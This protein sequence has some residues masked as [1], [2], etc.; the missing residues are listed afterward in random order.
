MNMILST[1][2]F[3][4]NFTPLLL[5]WLNI[6]EVQTRII[7]EVKLNNEVNIYLAN[8]TYQSTTGNIVYCTCPKSDANLNNF[9]CQCYDSRA[10]RTYK[11]YTCSCV[12]STEEIDF[13]NCKCASLEDRLTVKCSVSSDKDTIKLGVLIPHTLGSSNLS[14]YFSGD[15]YSSAMF[16]AKDDINQNKFLL[17]NKTVDLVWG[18]TDCNKTKTIKLA[19]KMIE[20]YH[21]DAIVGVGCEGCL[22]TATITGAYNI[23]MISHVRLVLFIFLLKQ[24][25]GL[26]FMRQ[27]DNF[28]L[29]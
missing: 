18:N 20:E 27:N 19:M 26:Y 29:R 1:F 8:C 6:Y 9:I 25:E 4:K 5:V 11:Q 12:Q 7:N 14:K 22:S 23:P 15:Y 24:S 16:I 17:K 2:S 10:N 28:F 21:V 3:I 13:N